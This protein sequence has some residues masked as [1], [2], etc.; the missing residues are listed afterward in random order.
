M[1]NVN[2][3]K[4]S[5][6]TYH[7]DYLPYINKWG[8]LTNWL[9]VLISFGPALV[10]AFVFDVMPP[11]SAIF[12]GFVGIAAAVGINWIVEPIS[13]FPIVGT[14]G[15]YMCFLAGNISNLRIPCA[16]IAQKV[17]EVEPGTD[18][19]SIVA[20]LG[21]AVSIV[22]NIVVLAVGV[23]ASNAILAQLP[24]SVFTALGFLLPALFGAIFGQFALK[25]IKIAPIALGLALILTLML[26]A[27]VFS[28]LPGRPTYVV[29]LGAV[30]G[31]IAIG[32][33][34]YKRKLV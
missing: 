24:K 2:S 4:V 34:L 8:K 10:L 31:T 17:A 20:T 22:V 13:Y 30:F 29:T 5:I 15:T 9:G 23:V 21:I 26:N 6:N 19:A 3:T 14:S 25:K 16:A 7:D 28:F 32:T 27:G 1:E 18:Q 33:A 11:V 12:A